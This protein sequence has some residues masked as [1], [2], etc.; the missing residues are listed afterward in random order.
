MQTEEVMHRLKYS[1]FILA[2]ILMMGI[3]SCATAPVAPADQTPSG[4]DGSIS[5]VLQLDPAVTYG[6]LENGLTYYIRRNATPEDRVQLR[7]VVDAGSIL[8]REDQLGLA[9]FVEHMAFNG[10]ASYE[11]NSLIDYLEKSG[12]SFGPDINALT[13]FDR[14][15]YKLDLPAESR[16][17]V[18]VG[19]DILKEWAFNISFDQEEVD[20]ER[21]V[22]IEEWRSGRNSSSRLRDEYLPVLLRNSRY[23]DRLPIGSMDVV[24]ASSAE[25]LREFYKTWYVPENMAVI[26]VGDIDPE[27]ILT[28]VEAVFSP[29]SSD[30]SKERPSYSVPAAESPAFIL[31]TDPE[32]R[33]TRVQIIRL[34]QPFSLATEEDYR[35][36]LA[37]SMYNMM[38]GDRLAEKTESPDPPYVNGY[39]GVSDFLRNDGATI[40][41][42][43]ARD[44]QTER[45]LRELLVEA[46]RIDRYG[47]T[48]GELRRAKENIASWMQRAYEER[49]K[50]ESVSLVNEYVAHFLS[51]EAAPGIEKEWELT[52]R[53]LPEITLDDIWLL[54]SRIGTTAGRETYVITG[55]EKDDSDYI[56]EVGL[57]DLLAEVENIELLPYREESEE[58]PFFDIPLEPGYIITEENGAEGTYRGFTLSNGA[59]V[60]Y[61]QTDFKN[62]EILFSAFSR[63]GA[64]LIEDDL[65]F[66]ARLAPSFVEAAGLGEFTPSELK[67]QLAGK[68]VR[69]SPFIGD[70]YEGF[71]GNARP[72]DLEVL[73]QLLHL[74]F[75][76]VREDRE[77]FESYRQ[78]LSVVLSNRNQNP[79]VQLGDTINELLYG[80]NPRRAPVTSEL[81]K[82]IEADQ[83]FSLFRQRF[84]SPSDF[85]FIFVGNV[86]PER[87]KELSAGYLGSLP[88]RESE[89]W[90]DRMVRY[91]EENRTAEV[92]S[93]IEEKSS[94]V[95][96]YPGD[97]SW[98]LR[99]A[100]LLEGLEQLINIRLREK[101]R[102]Q[103]GGTYGVGVSINVSRYP[104]EEYL[105]TINFS[106]DPARVDEL[107]GIVEN[108]LRN[109]QENPMPEEY[110]EKIRNILIKSLEDAGQTNE[111]WLRTISMIERYSL[112]PVD[113]LAEEERIRSLNPEALRAAAEKYIG[114]ANTVEAVLYPSGFRTISQQE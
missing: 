92:Y 83:V 94:V 57:Q 30:T 107:T 68:Q 112:D 26:I 23:A 108:E 85:T 56:T 103:A 84:A 27:E 42:A 9:H 64:S 20:K 59:K 86:D 54:G 51:G 95:R 69:V 32:A 82:N 78:R 50:T 31:A 91:T 52:R 79:D 46:R 61:R 16:E 40:W 102:E 76:S 2:A 93:G 60:L 106:C 81:V 109:L 73:Y 80:N 33:R 75:S 13:G 38:T 36:S 70:L 101:V 5:P 63:G 10:T 14:T 45:A 7:L 1:L 29:F 114:G 24:R 55:P 19:I 98:S 25:D 44:G 89:Q 11:K 28:E 49:D 41:G 111:Y 37:L 47:F 105:L 65:Y 4:A 110:I 8:E 17:T 97:L 88:P 67:K 100:S 74:Y 96:I 72:E 62:E 18:Q 34:H 43:T 77:L 22:I 104:E 6:S 12:M 21:K 71:S 35:T 3:T 87:I 66:S 39:F 48:A 15:V 90:L 99:E 53:F 113:V 58:K